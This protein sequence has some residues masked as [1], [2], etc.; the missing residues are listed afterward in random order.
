MNSKGTVFVSLA[1]I[2]IVV[3]VAFNIFFVMQ[4]LDFFE[5]SSA[6]EQ[7]DSPLQKD[8]QSAQG[9]NE[10]SLS[11]ET[12]EVSEKK[13]DTPEPQEVS[14]QST[15]PEKVPN[16]LGGPGGE[17]YEVG[18]LNLAYFPLTSDEKNID[19]AI[20][21]DVGDSFSVISQ[22]VKDIT[23][24]LVI[25]LEE[26]STYLGYQN[27]SARPA[28]HYTIVA[29]QAYT[30]SVPTLNSPRTRY[31]DYPRILNR[32]RVCE[33]VNN[34]G[35]REVWLF[36]YQGPNK[37][38]G[39]PSLSIDESKMSGPFGDIS[40]SYRYNEMPVCLHTYRVYTFNYGRGTSEA[41]ESWGHQMEAELS[42]VDAHLF[43]T[44]W[45]GANYPQ[46]LGVVGKCGSVHNPPNAR[47]EYDRAN[48]ISQQSDCLDWNP[49]GQGQLTQVSCG[50]WGCDDISDAN[51]A[52]LNY[53]IWNW[54]NLPGMGN[55]ITYQGK[56]LR[57]WW[58]VHGDFDNVMK[59]SKRL[60]LGK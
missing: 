45:Q 38:D 48:L 42:A 52:S 26:A 41:L 14:R 60:T 12:A 59:N 56:Q 19:I 3:L 34:Q 10:Q 31:P 53:M 33:Y 20:T 40:N 21:G 4:R 9:T 51:N 37:E 32:E 28:L 47:H 25:S 50:N 13:I 7:A 27:D 18:V 44:L 55:D 46:T 29:A 54:Q 39:A 43:R 36:A 1:L 5:R 22:R 57:N 49:D 15:P 16:F 58:E 23:D 2:S 6:G 17:G 30:E 24:N 35:V 11:A 8:A